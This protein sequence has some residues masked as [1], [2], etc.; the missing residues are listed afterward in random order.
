MAVHPPR[1][2]DRVERAF[3]PMHVTRIAPEIYEVVALDGDTYRVD[4]A[5]GACLC[6]DYEYRGQDRAGFA[7]K[8]LIR[9]RAV[10]EARQLEAPDE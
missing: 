3:E 1:L 5:I 8:H 10:E 2:P 4:L 7:C 6:E 9:A